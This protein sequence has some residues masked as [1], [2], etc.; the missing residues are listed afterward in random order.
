MSNQTIDI[1]TG[2]QAVLKSKKKTFPQHVNRISQLDDPCL[3]RLYYAR[4]DWDKATETDDGLQGIFETG[5][6]LEP[7]IERIA[8][9]YGIAATISRSGSAL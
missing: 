6:V 2:L 9:E 1:S 5:N 3:R 4:H 7:I 8:S